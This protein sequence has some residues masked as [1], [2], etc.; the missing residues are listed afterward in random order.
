MR[1]PCRRSNPRAVSLR[2]GRKPGGP[3]SIPLAP[4][5][6]ISVSTR[7][8]SSCGPQAA[9]S[10][11]PHETGDTATLEAVRPRSEPG[12]AML[13]ARALRRCMAG[14]YPLLS[15]LAMGVPYG[16]QALKEQYAREAEIGMIGNLGARI[17]D[18]D[19]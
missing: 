18:V 9:P 5:E 11:T 7:L 13:R 2:S 19:A 6:A 1:T 17:V 8:G 14:D 12:L 16:V 3:A 15:L 10:L 4:T